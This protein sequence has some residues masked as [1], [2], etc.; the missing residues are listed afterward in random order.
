MDHNIASGWTDFVGLVL[1]PSGIT[2]GSMQYNEMR[3]A[4]YAG[5][6][7]MFTLV[8]EASADP[9]EAVCLLHMQALSDELDHWAGLIQEGQV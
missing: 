1:T 5:A 9:V 6:A 3:R 2:A 7:T 4:F 8:N